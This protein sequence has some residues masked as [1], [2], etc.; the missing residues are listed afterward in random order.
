MDTFSTIFETIFMFLI[1]FLVSFVITASFTFM[2]LL[3]FHGCGLL[4]NVNWSWLLS[5][6]VWIVRVMLGGLQLV[7]TDLEE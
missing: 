4:L 3:C 7:E 6:G 2:A 5:L 1:E